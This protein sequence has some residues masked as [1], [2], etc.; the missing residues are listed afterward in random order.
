MTVM[1]K[2]PR[3][4]DRTDLR[5]IATL[6]RARKMH[7]CAVCPGYIYKDEEYYAVTIGGGG[8]GSLKHPARVHANC[9]EGYFSRIAA[10]EAAR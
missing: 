5:R 9:L 4:V 8:L 6:T 2:L 1:T 3:R 10:R 7:R